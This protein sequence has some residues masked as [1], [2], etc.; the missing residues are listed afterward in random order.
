MQVDVRHGVPLRQA[1]FIENQR[2]REYIVKGFT[3]E[4]E[5]L[6]QAGRR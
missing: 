3:L 2:L 1:R 4:D 5:R 6:E